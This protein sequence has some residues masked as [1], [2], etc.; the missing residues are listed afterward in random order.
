MHYDSQYIYV[1]WVE[2]RKILAIDNLQ[3]ED[4]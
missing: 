3:K 2:T 4:H 1:R